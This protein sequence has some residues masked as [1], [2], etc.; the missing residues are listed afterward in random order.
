MEAS[1]TLE[2][3][4]L[5]LEEA[6]EQRHMTTAKLV[7]GL[8]AAL[9]EQTQLNLQL[10]VQVERLST[11]VKKLEAD[12]M[13]HNDSIRSS[14]IPGT[15]ASAPSSTAPT[16]TDSRRGATI[17]ERQ[18]R[19]GRERDS[20][21]RKCRSVCCLCAVCVSVCVCVCLF[22]SLTHTHTHQM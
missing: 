5:R 21:E 2:K 12:L 4:L 17:R 19:A 3:R 16:P 13:F 9:Q 1:E 7:S 22:C 15:P 6:V 20:Q 18:R 10:R 14:P 8:E 11:R